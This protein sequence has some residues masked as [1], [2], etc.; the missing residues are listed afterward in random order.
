MAGR[1]IPSR[2][3]ITTAEF[4]LDKRN[5]PEPAIS[6]VHA[7]AVTGRRQT[8][9]KAA[10]VLLAI[11]VVSPDSEARDRNL[12]PGRYAPTGIYHDRVKLSVPYPINIDLAA[13][14]EL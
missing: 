10:D 14:D 13:I 11:E 5:G 8:H 4:V 6:V 9:F 12:K 3:G 7:R 1:R 2:G